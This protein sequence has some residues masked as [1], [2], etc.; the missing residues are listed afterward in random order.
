MEFTLFVKVIYQFKTFIKSF[1]RFH[2][3]GCVLYKCAQ[4][5]GFI[6]ASVTPM[7][8][9][10]IVIFY[11]E[12]IQVHLHHFSG[13]L[14]VFCLI[15]YPLSAW[16][17]WQEKRKKNVQEKTIQTDSLEANEEEKNTLNYVYV[18]VGL[19]SEKS[20]RVWPFSEVCILARYVRGTNAMRCAVTLAMPV[21]RCSFLILYSNQA[22]F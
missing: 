20:Y 13:I 17:D 19:E 5:F 11:S 14:S 2:G 7:T 3:M 15:S 6:L 18:I 21:T 9:A 4:C 1:I 16:M 10:L 12:P 8:F 22:I